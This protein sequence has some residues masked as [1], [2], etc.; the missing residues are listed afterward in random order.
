MEKYYKNFVSLYSP[1]KYETHPKGKE[2][3]LVL[4]VRGE[5][6]TFEVYMMVMRVLMLNQ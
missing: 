2:L 1:W 5:T 4:L 6:L 3:D